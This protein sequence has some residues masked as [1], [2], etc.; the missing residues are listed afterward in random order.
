MKLVILTILAQALAI[1]AE[2]KGKWCDAN[3]VSTSDGDYCANNL[4][5]FCCQD[6]SRGPNDYFVKWRGTEFLKD[7]KG[8]DVA[9]FCHNEQGIIFCASS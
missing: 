9:R 6:D 5:S 3:G 7:S 1:R 4:Y 8:Y 2:D